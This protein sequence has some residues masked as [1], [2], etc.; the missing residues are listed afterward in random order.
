M[1]MVIALTFHTKDP[2]RVGDALNIFLF[3][4]LSPFAG[5]EA[6]IVT[7]KLD[8]ILGG[9]TL[10]LFVEKSLLMEK[11][12]VV[13]VAGW[14]KAASQLENWA[15]FFMVFLGDDGVQPATYKMLLLLEDTSG[16][17]LRLR[18]HARHQPTFP[19]ALLCLIQQ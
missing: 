3:P 17:I 5:S 12:K 10:T 18:A 16:V 4:D 14:Y 7:R 2:D 13:T 19:A 8:A 11:Q 6:E 1:I 9:G 15:V